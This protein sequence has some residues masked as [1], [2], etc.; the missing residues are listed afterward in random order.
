MIN[1]TQALNQRIESDYSNYMEV[2]VREQFLIDERIA[3]YR[4]MMDMHKAEQ[5]ALVSTITNKAAEEE[6]KRVSERSKK[7]NE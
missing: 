7:I 3:A 4:R 2:D 1:E 5:V 6:R